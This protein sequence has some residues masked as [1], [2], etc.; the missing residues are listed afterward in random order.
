MTDTKIASA[1]TSQ[2]ALGSPNDLSTFLVP[3][4]AFP[5]REPVSAFIESLKLSD[6]FSHQQFVNRIY[7]SENSRYAFDVDDGLNVG[8]LMAGGELIGRPVWSKRWNA[9]AA[10]PEGMYN[11]AL[12]LEGVRTYRSF[13]LPRGNKRKWLYR[14]HTG[15]RQCSVAFTKED[16][17]DYEPLAR[18]K[19][20]HISAR[21]SGCAAVYCRSERYDDE[22]KAC[23]MTVRLILIEFRFRD[24]RSD[25]EQSFK[26]TIVA[27]RVAYSHRAG[28]INEPSI[29]DLSPHWQKVAYRARLIFESFCQ[30]RDDEALSWTNDFL[31]QRRAF[32]QARSAA[33]AGS[34]GS[35]INQIKAVDWQEALNSV[36]RPWQLKA[37]IDTHCNTRFDVSVHRS[38]TNSS[39]V[40]RMLSQHECSDVRRQ[41]LRAMVAD[42][43]EPMDELWSYSGD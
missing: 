30:P 21:R 32:L 1:S 15:K 3:A 35:F 25:V 6:D 16:G 24:A 14:L 9:N 11:V 38:D 18:L 22:G 4:F 27:S 20:L 41:E 28:E 2:F 36:H 29:S 26:R 8:H 31:D 33:S 7:G 43:V 39:R 34:S 37:V 12:L 19:P 13:S 17:S 10:K 42:F 40:G 23:G 5:S